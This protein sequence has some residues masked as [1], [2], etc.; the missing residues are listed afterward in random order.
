MGQNT[1]TFRIFLGMGAIALTGGATLLGMKLGYGLMVLFIVSGFTIFLVFISIMLTPVQRSSRA[2]TRLRPADPGIRSYVAAPTDVYPG[3]CWQCG[4][5]VKLDS[6]VC[7][8]CGAAQTHRVAPVPAPA[9]EPAPWEVAAPHFSG[10]L[11]R[12]DPTQGT[13]QPW[14]PPPPAAPQPSWPGADAIPPQPSW[15]GADA[16]PPPQLWGPP[17]QPAPP[18]SQPAASPRQRRGR[19]AA[20]A[21]QPPTRPERAP[22]DRV[23]PRYQPGAPAPWIQPRQPVPAEPARRRRR[24]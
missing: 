24:R 3:Y 15:P 6:V 22:S 5:H 16:V 2:K 17:P 21:A 19:P 12:W 4:R 8:R 11:T 1:G 20:P 7:L 18:A 13:P 10:G 14:G 9:S 23:A